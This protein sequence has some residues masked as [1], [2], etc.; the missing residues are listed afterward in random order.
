MGLPLAKM[1]CRIRNR[2]RAI[3]GLLVCTL[4]L[5]GAWAQGASAY[6]IVVSANADRS[7]AETLDAQSYQQSDHVYVFVTP[8]T[9][10]QRVSFYLD[11]TARSRAAKHVESL[12]PYDFVK[13]AD[14]GTAAAYAL[15]SLS[16]GDHTITAAVLKTDGKTEVDS[17]TFTVL[18]SSSSSLLFED[19]FNGSSLDNAAWAPYDGAGHARNG[20][21]R[22]SAF[23]VSNGNLV[24]TAKMVD[25]KIVSGGMKH[26]VD[27]TYGR[28]EFRVRTEVDPTGTMSGVVLTWPKAQRS[29]EFTEN[30]IYETGAGLNTRT[31]FRS[32]IHYGRSNSQ[33]YFIHN[34]D[35]SAWHTMA[36]DWR[37]SS[38]KIY[39]DGNLVWTITDAAVIP[40]VM[41]HVSIQLDARRTRTLTRTV[42]MYVDYIRVYR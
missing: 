40:D 14:D 31:P 27:Y 17:G 25:G 37:K 1:A 3:L 21:R 33:K 6:S 38:L 15:S 2:S 42:R 22:P 18:S 8:A 36:M 28:Y 23:S 11:D 5:S 20:L 39:R 35:A 24:I 26:R 4:V 19:N 13:T 34:A 29:P 16:A 12:A 32:F 7:D 30:D 10:V 41:H 9:G